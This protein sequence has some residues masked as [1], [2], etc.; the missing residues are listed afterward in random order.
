MSVIVQF[1]FTFS[2]SRGAHPMASGNQGGQ[3]KLIGET[4]FKSFHLNCIVQKTDIWLT[5]VGLMHICVYLSVVFIMF[6]VESA[7]HCQWLYTV[8]LMKYKY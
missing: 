3:M 6:P 5:P 2:R 7:R 8:H 4:F 1:M